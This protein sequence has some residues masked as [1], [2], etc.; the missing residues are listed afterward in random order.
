MRNGGGGGGEGRRWS[1]WSW[2]P[3]PECRRIFDIFAAACNYCA[4][5]QRC[6]AAGPEN[7]PTELWWSK[8]AVAS[9]RSTQFKPLRGFSNTGRRSGPESGPGGEGTCFLFS[10]MAFTLSVH[11]DWVLTE[12]PLRPSLLW[13]SSQAQHRRRAN[14]RGPAGVFTF[15]LREIKCEDFTSYIFFT[16]QV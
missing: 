11:L 6:S 9:K 2:S 1:K 12:P 16:L 4:R 14:Q 8:D 13:I 7:K 5:S 10:S 3:S 15:A